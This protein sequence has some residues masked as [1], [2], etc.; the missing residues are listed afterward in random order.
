MEKTV[1]TKKQQQLLN[2]LSK[3]S[4]IEDNFY[5]TGGTAL[6]E[7][8]LQHRLSEDL[9]FFSFEEIEINAIQIIFKKI[10]KEANFQKISYE[11]SFNR[12]LFFLHFADE[13]IKTEFT[14]YPFEQVQKPLKKEGLRID[15]LIDIAVNKTST[16]FT[17]PRTRDFIDLFLILQ[18]EKWTFAELNNPRLEVE[19][20]KARRLEIDYPRMIIPFDYVNCETFWL[21]EAKKLEKDILK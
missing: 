8:Y 21:Q 14:Y 6:A 3:E 16:I 15:S 18:R 13:I 11:N 19:G 12:N 2:L 4:I 9:D 1:L 20:F 10:K 7:Y 17:T 5:L